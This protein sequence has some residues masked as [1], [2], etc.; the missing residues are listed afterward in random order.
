M[1][2]SYGLDYSLRFTSSYLP[3]YIPAQ[4]RAGNDNASQ[5]G[6]LKCSS[7]HVKQGKKE[8]VKLI[9]LIF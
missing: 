5:V 9:L 6:M 4:A 8:K 3:G 1:T 7:S 2:L